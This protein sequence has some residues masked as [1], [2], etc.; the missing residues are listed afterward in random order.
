[1]KNLELPEDM[2]HSFTQDDKRII[3]TDKKI[4]DF[5]ASDHGLDR[6]DLDDAELLRRLCIS[7]SH[8]EFD[9][10]WQGLKK[11][12]T[13]AEKADPQNIHVLHSLAISATGYWIEEWQTSD[14]NERMRIA[15]DGE[16]AL[17]RAM[18][19][20]PEN[21]DLFYTL[22]L[23]YYNHPGRLDPES[24]Y[25]EKAMNAFIK[26]T[27]KDPDLQMAHLYKA[28]CYHDSEDWG[29]AYHSY[30]QVDCDRLVS[31]HPEWRWRMFKR[32]EQLALC[33]AKLGKT[34]E[35][36]ERFSAFF[37][38]IECLSPDDAFD[39]VVNMDETVQAFTTVINDLSLYSRMINLLKRLNLYDYYE[40]DL[41]DMNECGS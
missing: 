24:E 4:A 19:I 2:I 7:L 29:A 28:H 33:A 37:D 31:E 21:A 9:E 35:T 39:D 25:E 23:L 18:T 20:E 26:A 10:G 17:I 27:E 40:N 41:T 6:L 36:K 8:E 22:G 32:N 13:A 5:L 11:I 15:D 30:L 38:E 14:I 12:Y 16:Q 1:M 3:V 34:E